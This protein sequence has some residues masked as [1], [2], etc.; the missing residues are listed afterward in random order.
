MSIIRSIS[1]RLLSLAFIFFSLIFSVKAEDNKDKGKKK[2]QNQENVVIYS[3]SEMAFLEQVSKEFEAKVS[4]AIS[5]TLERGVELIKVVDS[6]GN[7]ILKTT[8]MKDIPSNA[9]KLMEYRKI[10]FYIVNL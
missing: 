3:A 2:E 5:N 7:V 6:E 1:F 4:K 8:E 10:A 9:E